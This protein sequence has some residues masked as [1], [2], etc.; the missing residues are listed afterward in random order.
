MTYS[1]IHPLSASADQVRAI[2]VASLGSRQPF[3]AVYQSSTNPN[4]WYIGK[5]ANGGN[6]N[7]LLPLD[8]L[9]MNKGY[10]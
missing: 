9:Q 3:V 4:K 1:I 10:M 6:P 7:H 8:W 2:R 5:H